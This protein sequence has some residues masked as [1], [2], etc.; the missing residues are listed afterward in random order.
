MVAPLKY[1]LITF[2]LVALEK[3]SLSNRKIPKTLAADD[4]HYLLNRNNL[5]QPIQMQLSQKQKAFAEFFF[6]FL[7]PTLNFKHLP[8]KADVFPKIPAPKNMVR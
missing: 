8:K 2:K 3:L 6:A 1:L 5:A 7:K 4:K